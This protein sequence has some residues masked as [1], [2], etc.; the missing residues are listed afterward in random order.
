MNDGKILILNSAEVRSLLH[1]KERE[2]METVRLAYETH[3]GGKSSLPHSSFLTFPDNNTDR[4][5]A[6]PAYLGGD[7][8]VAGIKWISSFP[9]NHKQEIDRA[10]AVVILNSAVT[11][12]AEAIVEGSIISA[13]RT[14]A[15]AA[16]AA[17]RLQKD[18]TSVS[19][20]GCGVINFEIVRFL[21]ASFTDLKRLVIF[22]ID[23]DR[24]HQFKRRCRDLSAEVEISEVNDS[25]EALA[26][27]PLI[28]FATTA[29]KP[30]IFDLSSCL[31][32]STIL[33]ISLRDLSP[34]VILSCDNLTDDIDHVCRAQTSLHLTEQL[35]GHRD[36]IRCTLADVLLGTSPARKDGDIAVFSPF[37]LGVLDIAVCQLVC[38]LARKENKGTILPFLP[39]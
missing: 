29:V 10:S 1:G 25:T 26:A 33:H 22:D 20:I 13:R 6:L 35:T 19:L 14:A 36:F 31:P 21:L 12:R 11:G 24:A 15:S 4:I 2:L 17:N 16:L 30:H 3:A 9:M 39:N 34:E 32:Q 38:N 27:S 37:G 5:I 7:F 8:Q 23:K 28:S 18:A